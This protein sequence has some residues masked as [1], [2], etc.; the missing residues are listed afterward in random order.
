M[1]TIQFKEGCAAARVLTVGWRRV[2]DV[3]GPSG[4]WE[5]LEVD[6]KVADPI[7]HI[8]GVGIVKDVQVDKIRSCARCLR[9]KSRS[10]DLSVVTQSDVTPQE[11]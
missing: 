5:V 6:G 2:Q 4:I 8:L 10:C 9:S 11:D 1:V 3:T 7:N